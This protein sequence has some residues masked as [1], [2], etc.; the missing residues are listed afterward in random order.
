MTNGLLSESVLCVRLNL[1]AGTPSYKTYINT[2]STS[3]LHEKFSL[4]FNKA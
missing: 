4:V 2:R 1:I 3:L